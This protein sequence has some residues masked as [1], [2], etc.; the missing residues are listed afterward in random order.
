M[1]PSQITWVF[2]IGLAALT[3]GLILPEYSEEVIYRGGERIVN[4]EETMK[5]PLMIAGGLLTLVGVSLF[6]TDDGGD[7]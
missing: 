2:I 7:E 5:D 3:L 4:R 6:L 1:N